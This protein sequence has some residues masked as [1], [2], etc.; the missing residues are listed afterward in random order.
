MGRPLTYNWADVP[1]QVATT[2]LQALSVAVPPV[3]SVD[4][5]EPL[6]LYIRKFQ[7]VAAARWKNTQ[8]ER[9]P[10]P[11]TRLATGASSLSDAVGMAQNSMLNGLLAGGFS[12]GR[13]GTVVF[14]P[15]VLLYTT[16]LSDPAVTTPVV[17][18]TGSALTPLA[19]APRLPVLNDVVAANAA[20]ETI[21]DATAMKAKQVSEMMVRCIFS[22][23]SPFSP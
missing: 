19:A 8:P 10:V 20:D 16:A 23:M 15:V 7:P 14:T 6:P 17:S 4:S 22:P 3:M 9:L 11:E 13:S 21:K 18:V 1:F 2:W 5:P 12:A